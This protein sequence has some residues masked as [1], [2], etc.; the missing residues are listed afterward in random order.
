[1]TNRNLKTIFILSAG[2]ILLSL[3]SCYR[4]NS[5]NTSLN[6]EV[7]PMT[8]SQEGNVNFKIFSYGYDPDD[9]L[10]RCKMDAI[11]A[12]LFKGIP[13]SSQE[14]P[15]IPNLDA[16]NQHKEYFA[17]FFGVNSKDI[18]NT[19]VTIFGRIRLLPGYANGPYRLFVNFSGDGSIN[20]N[21]RMK[22]DNRYK[23][24][25]GMSVNINLLR[26]RLEKDGIIK[27]FEF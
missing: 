18:S 10:E 17:N 22:V 26:K 9:A 25:V 13:G 11:H 15:L 27:G 14:K 3:G 5:G 7:F 6:Y 2:V 21:D 12:V 20:P 4:K 19:A 24:G 1:M 23:V 16:F 8:Q